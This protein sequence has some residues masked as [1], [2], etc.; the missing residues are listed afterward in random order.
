MNLLGLWFETPWAFLGLLLVPLLIWRAGRRA[1]FGRVPAPNAR[2]FDAVNKGIVARL[3]W[4]PDALRIAAVAVLVVAVARPQTEDRQVLTGDGVDIMVA[5]DMSASMNAVDLS[6]EELERSLA[7]G[8]EPGNRFEIATETLKEFIASRKQDRIGLVIFGP[9]AWLKYPLTLDYGR[10]IS[11]L[12][13]L[14]LDAGFQDRDTGKC[15]NDCT[16]S[17][18]GTAIGDALGRAFNRLRRSESDSRIV[19]LITDGKQEGGSLDPLAIARHIRNLPRD[20][21]VRIYTFLVGSEDQTWVPAIDFRGRPRT[22]TRGLPVYQRPSQPF[23]TD[24]ELLRRIA[25]MT[26]GK[27]YESY[28]EE[29]FQEDV[30]DLERTVFSSRVHVT[31]SDVFWPLALAALLLIALEW[32]LRFTRWRSLV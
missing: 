8:E 17:G 12:D 27:F 15:I 32:F 26:G 31:R 16:I 9:R 4:L 7:A 18:A 1:R 3:W 28:D 13:E 20:E 11:T 22:D 24:P 6:E 2:A 29:K 10:L 5:L 30:A 23:P 19:V 21:R 14:I 25:E